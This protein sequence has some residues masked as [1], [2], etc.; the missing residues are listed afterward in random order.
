MGAKSGWESGV[1]RS[2]LENRSGVP[3]MS[4]AKRMQEFETAEHGE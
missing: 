3:D 1:T 2:S 4:F